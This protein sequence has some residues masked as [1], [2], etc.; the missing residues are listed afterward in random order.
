MIWRKEKKK[1]SQNGKSG[2]FIPVFWKQNNAV[3]GE[4]SVKETALL[5]VSTVL[6]RKVLL[7]L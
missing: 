5:L 3:F 6:V 7:V 4:A 1:H 2:G